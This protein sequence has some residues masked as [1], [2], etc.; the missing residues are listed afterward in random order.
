MCLLSNWKY[1]GLNISHV[2]ERERDVDCLPWENLVLCLTSCVCD[3]SR[4][5]AMRRYCSV[6][7]YVHVSLIAIKF[8]EVYVVS[9]IIRIR[10]S[11]LV[12]GIM[13]PCKL[14]EHIL[15]FSWIIWHKGRCFLVTVYLFGL[16]EGTMNWDLMIRRMLPSSMTAV[17]LRT[18]RL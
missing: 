4:L 2:I 10:K 9:Q 8:Y 5:F 16:I 14:I 3:Y 12:F 1:T 15:L 6:P 17:G 7:A 11:P 18:L 13:F